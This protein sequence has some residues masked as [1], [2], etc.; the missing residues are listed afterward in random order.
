MNYIEQ[1]KNEIDLI[2]N[3]VI[4]LWAN[5]DTVSV[6]A[7][8]YQMCKYEDKI[9]KN[10]LIL[11]DIPLNYNQSLKDNEVKMLLEENIKKWANG[12]IEEKRTY[13]IINLRR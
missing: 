7:E 1:L 11:F 10:N 12:I 2:P 5:S 13:R 8:E 3:G 6:L 4:E 9:D